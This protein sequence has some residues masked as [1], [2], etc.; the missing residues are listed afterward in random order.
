MKVVAVEQEEKP[1]AEMALAHSCLLKIRKKYPFLSMVQI[2]EKTG[3]GNSTLHRIENGMGNPTLRTLMRLLSSLGLARTVAEVEMLLQR[4]GGGLPEGANKH[5][6]HVKYV[7]ILDEGLAERFKNKDHSMILLMASYTGGTTRKEIRENYG[8]NG[9]RLLNDMVRTGILK[10]EEGAVKSG[11]ADQEGP[12]TIDHRT[13]KEMLV[14][15]IQEKYD[16]DLYGSGKNWLSFQGESVDINKAMPK[17]R[18]I[19]QE[20]FVNIEK[21]LRAEEY[22]GTDK[23]FV[24]M[25]T[26]SL[27][28]YGVDQ[29]GE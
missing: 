16:P 10:E 13:F 19:I 18:E 25:V 1:S 21:V 4:E 12:W 26:D 17:V 23:M 5:L 14:N 22:R 20:A 2:A 3:I 6:S 24:G 11:V 8:I 27:L 15:C 29:H 9:I 7:P 28:N